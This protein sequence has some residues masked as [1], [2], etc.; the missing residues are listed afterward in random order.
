MERMPLAA[1]LDAVAD[2]TPTPGG[3]AVASVV[4]ALAAALAQMVVAFSIGRKG[5]EAHEA[6]LRDA[7]QRLERARAILLRLAVEDA[8]AFTR[9]SGLWKL[10]RDDPQRREQMP[11]MAR[12]AIQVPLAA[13]ATASDLGQLF[14]E[15]A[16]RTNPQ[17]RSDLGIAAVLSAALARASMWNVRINLPLLPSE[18][19]RLGVLEEAERLLARA[20][21]Q[22]EAA[23]R[24]CE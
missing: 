13:M 7:K 17:L 22:A 1:L 6:D 4:G 3:G 15:L 20:V 16:P 12:L 11:M 14:V 23:E 8:E 5:L 18:E 10:A 21:E 9:L 19:E 24:A 2:R